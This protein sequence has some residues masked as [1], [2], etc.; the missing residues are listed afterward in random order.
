MWRLAR[1]DGKIFTKK[2]ERISKNRGGNPEWAKPTRDC[3]R[4]FW[5]FSQVFEGILSQSP[6]LNS[7]Y[8]HS[9]LFFGRHQCYI[10]L[11]LVDCVVARSATKLGGL[12]AC[13]HSREATSMNVQ[14][15]PLGVK[16]QYLLIL[17]SPLGVD[18]E[19]LKYD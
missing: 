15:P 7:T 10:R 6:E 1:V 9:L 18:T 8:R 17:A 14:Y 5:I 12:G 2:R 16:T 11:H 3:P 19:Y 13:P 4:G